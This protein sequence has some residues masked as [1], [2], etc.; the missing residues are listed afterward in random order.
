MLKLY[1]PSPHLDS[2][3]QN[4][5]NKYNKNLN[6]YNEKH[7]KIKYF[8]L[9]FIKDPSLTTI[10]AAGRAYPSKYGCAFYFGAV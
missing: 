5:T 8:H 3:R 9:I 1:E 4:I 6:K 10:L 7:C 2:Q